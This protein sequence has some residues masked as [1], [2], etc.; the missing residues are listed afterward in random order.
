MKVFVIAA[1]WM[2]MTVFVPFQY[3][4]LGFGE[5][6][7]F[8]GAEIFFF[9]VV[10]MIPFEIRDLKY[11]EPEL[12]T[13]PQVLGVTKTKWFATALLIALVIMV[14]QQQYVYATY[15]PVNLAV[16]AVTLILVWFS[17]KEQGSY[18]ASFWVES[19]PIAWLVGYLFI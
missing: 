13:I 8:Q 11:D 4:H 12:A 10:L 3:H 15:L 17:K 7:L 18:Y 9:V 19:I 6:A 16:L 2:G 5:R 14:L 1:V